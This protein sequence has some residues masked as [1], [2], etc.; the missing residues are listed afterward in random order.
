MAARGFTGQRILIVDDN[1][2]N[3]TLV[4]HFLKKED[5]SLQEAANGQEALDVCANWK[6]DLILL[7]LHMP[8]LD[9]YAMLEAIQ[10]DGQYQDLQ[11]IPVLLFTADAMEENILR[12]K[13]YDT[14]GILT[15]PLSRQGLIDALQRVLQPV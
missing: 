9:G 4:Q 7:D 11:D 6:P 10:E 15:K 5:L 8:V 2:D 13:T 3:R 1:E 14:A 12:M